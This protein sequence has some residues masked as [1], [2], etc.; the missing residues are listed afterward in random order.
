MGCGIGQG[1][2][3]LLGNLHRS[4]QDIG[5]PDAQDGPAGLAQQARL[6]TVTLNVPPNLRD[7]VRGVVTSAELPE[8][9]LQVASVPEIAVAEDRETM[10]WEHNVRVAR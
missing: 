10:P 4:A 6:L 3:N 7:P 5:L 9:V 2:N 1:Y 8:P